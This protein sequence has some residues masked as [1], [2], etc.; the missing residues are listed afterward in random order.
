MSEHWTVSAEEKLLAQDKRHPQKL[1]YVVLLKF[2]Q[3]QG[4]FPKSAREV[5][6]RV[7]K[8]I[9]AQLEID[10]KRWTNYDWTG[11]TIKYHRSEIRKLLGFRE[12]TV[13]DSEALAAGFVS[14]AF[15]TPDEWNK[16]RMQLMSDCVLCTWSHPP[17][18]V[19][20]G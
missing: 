13:A 16:S 12:A 17:L 18:N 5:P 15:Q 1:G 7:I 8:Q 11:R 14:T 20:A 10:P 4:R 9:S 2:F 3:Y 6:R 19:S